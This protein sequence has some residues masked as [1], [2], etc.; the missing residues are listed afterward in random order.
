MFCC[1]GWMRSGPSL[2]TSPAIIGFCRLALSAYDG[3]S[4]WLPP[5]NSCFSSGAL[6][7]PSGISACMQSNSGRPCGSS[8]DTPAYDL[9]RSSKSLTVRVRLYMVHAVCP[10][11][12]VSVISR[13]DLYAFSIDCRRRDSGIADAWP[14]RK[15]SFSSAIALPQSSSSEWARS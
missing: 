15:I 4:A 11:L 6:R 1:I 8:S 3:P 2:S 10:R 13:C 7:Q 5:Y 12:S 14:V 9:Y